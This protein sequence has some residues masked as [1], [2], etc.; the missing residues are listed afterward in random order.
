MTFNL[1]IIEI[2]NDNVP[3]SRSLPWKQERWIDSQDIRVAKINRN[4]DWSAFCENKSKNSR[5]F[6]INIVKNQTP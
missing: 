2:F 5:A 3:L 6:S 1:V 4:L